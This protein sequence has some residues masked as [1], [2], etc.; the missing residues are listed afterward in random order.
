MLP[1]FIGLPM[2][3]KIKKYWT[4]FLAA[5]SAIL[6]ILFLLQKSKSNSLEDK[7]VESELGKKDT[8]LKYKEK[9]IEKDVNKL[10]ESIKKTE[11]TPIDVKD[12]SPKEVED[13]WKKQ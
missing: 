12:L 13:Y 4:G 5:V 10:K 3:D 9:E 8:E 7:L 2:L 11:N 6:G 1:F